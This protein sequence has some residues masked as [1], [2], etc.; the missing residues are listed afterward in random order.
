MIWIESRLDSDYALNAECTH[1]FEDYLAVAVEVFGKADARAG[2]AGQGCSARPPKRCRR[3]SSPSSAD[4]PNPYKNARSNRLRA[5]LTK[6][7]P[8]GTRD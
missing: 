4:E 3:I 8:A 7:R 1:V 5:D 2:L 6:D